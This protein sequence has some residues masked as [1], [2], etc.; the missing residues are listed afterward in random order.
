MVLN[1]M[2]GNLEENFS[3][4]KQHLE[5][6]ERNIMAAIGNNGKQ[7]EIADLKKQLATKEMQIE[8]LK[9]R[10]GS[11]ED[12]IKKLTITIENLQLQIDKPKVNKF[13]NSKEILIEQI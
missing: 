11:K 10:C 7:E 1:Q 5:Q 12:Y 9:E 6:L 2:S 3:L 4:L 13:D 8:V